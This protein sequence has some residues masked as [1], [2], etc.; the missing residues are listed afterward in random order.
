LWDDL[1]KRYQN[2]Y[3]EKCDVKWIKL[4]NDKFNEETVLFDEVSGLGNI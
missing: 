1:E 4:K 3:L 2:R